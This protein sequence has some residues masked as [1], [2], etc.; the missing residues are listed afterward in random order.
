[1]YVETER[2]MQLTAC[3]KAEEELRIMK[4]TT[5]VVASGH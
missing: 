5:L 4:R 2:A 3:G 1:M